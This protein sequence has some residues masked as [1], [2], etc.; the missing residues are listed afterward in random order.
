MAVVAD[1]PLLESKDIVLSKKHTGTLDYEQ[2]N[3]KASNLAGKA[4]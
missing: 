4:K 1:K 3:T 2:N